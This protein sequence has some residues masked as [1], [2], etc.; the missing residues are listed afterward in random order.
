M[1][2]F[3]CVVS[4]FCQSMK[5]IL[6]PIQ[7]QKTYKIQAQQPF[8]PA[9][10]GFH[11]HRSSPQARGIHLRFFFCIFIYMHN[12][13]CNEIQSYL[14]YSQNPSH[15]QVLS[16]NNNRFLPFHVKGSMCKIMLNRVDILCE[17]TSFIKAPVRLIIQTK[18]LAV[19]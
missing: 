14:C 19:N 18:P 17:K 7:N 2:S 4:S 9:F 3:I 15:P 5:N 13:H 6:E 10:Q 11:L 16:A 8:S 12:M 1:L